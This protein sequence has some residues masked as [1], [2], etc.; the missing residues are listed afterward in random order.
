MSPVCKRALHPVLYVCLPCP[1]EPVQEV[2]PVMPIDDQFATDDHFGREC[3]STT[4]SQWTTTRG[5]C[6]FPEAVQHCRLSSPNERSKSV[7]ASIESGVT[8][9]V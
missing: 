4:I 2:T 9:A 5:G 1:L 3:P 6:W 8:C 7:M